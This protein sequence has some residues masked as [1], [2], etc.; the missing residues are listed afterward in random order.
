MIMDKSPQKDSK[1]NNQVYK[2]NAKF[3]LILAPFVVIF[4]LKILIELGLLKKW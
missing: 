2:S 4:I 1:D 3:L